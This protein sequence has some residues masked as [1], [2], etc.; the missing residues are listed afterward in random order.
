MGRLPG[1]LFWFRNRRLPA[2]WRGLSASKL[3]AYEKAFGCTIHRTLSV[4][5]RAEKGTPY[6]AA[7]QEAMSACLTEEYDSPILV[8]PADW[9][10]PAGAFGESCGPT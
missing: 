1:L 6:E 4:I 9:K 3:A 10:M 2:R 5:E 8:P 7:T